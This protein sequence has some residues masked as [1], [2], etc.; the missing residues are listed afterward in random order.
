MADVRISDVGTELVVCIVDEDGDVV[1]VSAA[2]AKTI[3]LKKP[4]SGGAVLAKDASL[5]TTGTDGKIK[6]VTTA[7]DLDTAGIW[8]IQGRVTVAGATWSSE[9][10]EFQVKRNLA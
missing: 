10:S 9:K 3:F 1:D 8:R 6:W 7:G 4:G 5:D 2:S